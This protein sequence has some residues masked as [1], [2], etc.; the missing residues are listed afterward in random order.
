MYITING[1]KRSLNRVIGFGIIVMIMATQFI[2][3]RLD[4]TIGY[5]EVT[6]QP[7]DTLES[8]IY[9]NTDIPWRGNIRNLVYETKEVNSDTDLTTIYPGQKI[10]IAIYKK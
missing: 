2:F 7:G 4:P 1:K 8:I 6:V 10:V 9:E 5:R 3:G